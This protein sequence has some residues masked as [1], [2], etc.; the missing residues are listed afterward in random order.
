LT[1]LLWGGG[2]PIGKLAVEEASAVSVGALR[3]L[4]ATA[5]LL[6]IVAVAREGI[7]R[8]AWRDLPLWIASGVIGIFAYSLM[9]YFALEVAPASD[10]AMIMPTISPVLTAVLAVIFL[11]ERVTPW[12][13]LGLAVAAVGEALVI[14]GAFFGAGLSLSRLL[15]D[16]LFLGSALAWAC[17]SVLNRVASRRHSALMGTTYAFLVGVV[18]LVAVA[19]PKL[20]SD[21]DHMR[22]PLLLQVSYLGILGTALPFL[23]YYR[24]VRQIG[25]GR[26]S[27][28]TLYLAPVFSLVISVIFLGERP[29]AIQLLGMVIILGSVWLATRG[30]GP[31]TP[32][33]GEEAGPPSP[34]PV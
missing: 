32:E 21:A 2:Y 30:P 7:T 20:V 14:Q 9:T 17:Y 27:M 5:A 29:G 16:A 10:G 31:R 11:R 34:T 12:H 24:G 4:L 25:A 26:T 3:Y 8:R 18:L 22:A 6:A 15:G 33:A 23:L 19:A 1:A 28:F 13:V